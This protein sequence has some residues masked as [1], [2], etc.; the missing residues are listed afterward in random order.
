M[1]ST[2]EWISWY[3]RPIAELSESFSLLIELVFKEKGILL[4]VYL[5]WESF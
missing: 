1:T 3:Q 4:P 2:Y 5:R